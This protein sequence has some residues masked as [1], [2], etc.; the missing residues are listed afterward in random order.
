MINKYSEFIL[1]GRVCNLILENDMKASMEFMYKLEDI[2]DDSNIANIIYN[3]FDF[4][5][6]ID[7][8]LPQNWVSVTDKDDTISFLPDKK[9]DKLNK[10]DDFEVAYVVKG[11]SEMKIG[12]FARA[13]LT[14]TE[15]INSLDPDD[16]D[17]TKIEFT[18]KEYE[19]FVNLYK[20]TF[21][22]LNT[23]FELVSGQRIKECYD[24]DNY[25]YESRGQLGNSCMKLDS[26]QE[27]FGIYTENPDVCRLLVLFDGDKIL[28]RAIVWKL[29][30]SPCK[31]QYFMDRVYTSSDSDVIKFNNY[32]DKEG[33][34]R[35]Y[36]NNCDNLDSYYFIYKGETIMGEI[37]VKLRNAEFDKYPF[38][39]TLKHIVF[40]TPNVATISNTST[41]VCDF[42][43]STDGDLSFCTTCQGDGEL[44]G[45]EC[46]ECYGDG[47]NT[48][49][50]CDGDGVIL[51]ISGDKKE[52]KECEGTGGIKCIFCD[53]EG[54]L[55]GNCP[56]CV[57][58][59]ER[60][61]KDIIRNGKGEQPKLAKEFWDKR[62]SE[63]KKGKKKK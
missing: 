22:K 1:E 58:M 45:K 32:C 16:Y 56:D 12:R 60:D 27:Y 17:L 20:S 48:C 55:N 23:K 28:G 47:K 39:D 49:Q 44:N 10:D 19:D 50:E 26:C 52:C 33:W 63:N 2:K 40:T 21:V 57:G 25:K 37:S 7:E 41:S 35:K 9:A 30:K 18:D 29:D 54:Y 13:L 38:V 62:K 11:R 42:M 8:D 15:V 36:K 34:M 5:T 24:V 43:D 6:Y 31:S 46:T 14:N 61:I 51:N 59:I 3:L 53:G 4:E